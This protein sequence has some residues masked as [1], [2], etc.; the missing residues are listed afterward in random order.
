[1][2]N[3]KYFVGEYVR[4]RKAHKDCEIDL[5]VVDDNSPDG[6][7]EYIKQKAT[8]AKGINL[9]SSINKTGLASAYTRGFEYG[10]SQNYSHFIQ[11]D[12]DGSHSFS[13]LARLIEES[14]KSEL[15]IG[16]RWVET[17][18]TKNWKFHRY[19]LS[20]WGNFVSCKI[21]KLPVKDVSS[22][23]RI[24]S[25][26]LLTQVLQSPITV[27]GYVFQTEM[28]RRSFLYDV[29]ITEI[30]ITFY[31]RS[32]GKSKMS[33]SILLENLR[34]LIKFFLKIEYSNVQRQ[35]F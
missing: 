16:S 7:G 17:G 13:D 3:I 19:F 1:M 23:F 11:M 24:Y 22:G 10:I 20:K 29:Q 30:G 5:L 8:K 14:L 9:L 28:T 31:D 18:S 34:Y 2:E 26:S 4:Y 27:K 35:R 15:V 21:L 25:K 33:L 12:A 32:F 6:T